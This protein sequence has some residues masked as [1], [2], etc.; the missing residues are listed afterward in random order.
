M[1]IN[2]EVREA[3]GYKSSWPVKGDRIM[4]LRNN[5]L[6]GLFNGMQGDLV[7]FGKAKNHIDFYSDGGSYD[8]YFEPSSFNSEKPEI[9]MSRNDPDPFE[10]AYCIT[11]HKSQGDEWGTVMVIE[12]K[13]DNWEH[14]RWAYTAASRAKDKLIWVCA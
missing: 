4:C 2:K 13:C 9:S 14:K 1:K 3:L 6:R 12:Q 11:A 5:Y 7:S 8:L 10:Y